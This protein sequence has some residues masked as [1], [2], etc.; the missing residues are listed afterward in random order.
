MNIE[1]PFYCREPL[2]R[3]DSK[4]TD[5]YVRNTLWTWLTRE[6]FENFA[7]NIFKDEN[8]KTV[9]NTGIHDKFAINLHFTNGI[10]MF[11]NKGYKI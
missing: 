1:Y 4:D 7:L 3:L 2:Y 5:V 9:L 8:G 11:T 6:G 10:T